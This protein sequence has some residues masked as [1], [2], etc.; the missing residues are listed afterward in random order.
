MS[1]YVRLGRLDSTLLIVDLTRTT[2]LL[3]IWEVGPVVDCHDSALLAHSV[4]IADM[5]ANTIAMPVPLESTLM[6]MVRV[7]ART[8][9]RTRT[10]HQELRRAHINAQL[11]NFK[12]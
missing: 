1:V 9:K 2:T 4:R 12:T 5:R 11:A 10:H 7:C 3:A 6:L 8:V